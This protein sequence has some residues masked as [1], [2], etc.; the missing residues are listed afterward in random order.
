MNIVYALNVSH[1]FIWVVN[2]HSGNVSFK[3]H[4]SLKS[5]NKKNINQILLFE[6]DSL[7]EG[8]IKKLTFTNEHKLFALKRVTMKHVETISFFKEYLSLY[9]YILLYL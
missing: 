5:I 3:S 7:C 8:T 2:E 9:I 4:T 6:C 1:Y